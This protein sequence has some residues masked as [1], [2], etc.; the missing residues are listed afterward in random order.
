[1]PL[2]PRPAPATVRWWCEPVSAFAGVP[3]LP[4][5]AHRIARLAR[6]ADRLRA[7]AGTELLRRAVAR[8]IGV[9]MADLR[10]SRSC[11]RCGSDQH[12]KPWF[13]D[14]GVHASLS[15][16]G[17]LVAV[18]VAAQPV[19]IDIEA[20]AAHTAGEWELDEWVRVESV[21]KATGDGLAVDPRSV[22]LMLDGDHRRVTAYG[23][24][25]LD[26]VTVDL[27]AVAGAVG[28][29]TVLGTGPVVL[30]RGDLGELDDAEE[31]GSPRA[32]PL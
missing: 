15:H 8:I 17:G 5:D 24:G 31:F 27:P 12:G 7:V 25:A 22:A 21:V 9:R 20:L 2:A 11:R 23:E 26:G 28:A 4:A 18:A 6:D 3:V 16:S 1:M 13:P 30:R 19:G 10:V 32:L 29:V 14:T